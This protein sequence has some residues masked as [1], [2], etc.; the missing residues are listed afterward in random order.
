MPRD[1]YY[2]IVCCLAVL[3]VFVVDIILSIGCVSSLSAKEVFNRNLLSVVE[4]K[5]MTNEVGESFGTGEFVNKDGT[6]V[7]NAH[8]VTYSQTGEKVQFEEFFIRFADSDDY[9][10]VALV[11]FDTDLDIAVLKYEGNEHQFKAVEMN[12]DGKLASGDTV[13][14]I[15]NAMNYGLAISSGI[16]SVPLVNISYD[17]VT[18]SVIQCD[19]TIAEGNSGGA[20]FD[21]NGR[22]VGIT[23]F[24]TKDN[25]GVVVYGFAYCLPLAT[26]LAYLAN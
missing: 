20:L 15:G 6:L 25:K 16:V 26:V 1:N 21:K 3:I 18:R 2:M 11:K 9:L 22:L 12:S 19:I 13:F 14:A 7:T 5:A 10:S 17:G 8:V 24:R 23:T 4:V